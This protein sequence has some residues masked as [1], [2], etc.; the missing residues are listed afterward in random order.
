MHVNLHFS[1]KNGSNRSYGILSQGFFFFFL[2][3]SFAEMD[4]FWI[5]RACKDAGRNPYQDDHYDRQKPSSSNL[6]TGLF[7]LLP[8]P[9]NLYHQGKNVKSEYI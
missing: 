4:C 1:G 3:F 6:A 5:S 7:L 2:F 8:A 9:H